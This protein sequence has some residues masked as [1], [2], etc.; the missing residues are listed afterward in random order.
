[1][2]QIKHSQLGRFRNGAIALVLASTAALAACGPTNEPV[3]EEPAVDPN[4]T[5]EE[6]V[7]E[8]P[9]EIAEEYNVA[10]GDLTGNVEDY[11]GQAV[12]VRGEAE[13][14]L[15]E[16]SFLLQDDQLF[17]GEEVV[18]FNATGTPFLLPTDDEPTEDVQV[19]GEV[20]QLV[21]ADFEREYGLDLD[22]QLYTEY[23]DRPALVAES[24]AFSP[25]PEEVTEQPEQYYGQT[26]AVSGEIGEQF[27]T[28]AFRLQEEGWFEG[29]EVLVIGA[30]VLPTVEE[31]EE[32]VVTG[33][34]RPYVA[35]EFERDYDL[36]WDLDLQEQIEAE[37]TDRPV[38]VADEVYPSAQ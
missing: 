6:P 19:T 24:I 14:A 16:S 4:V 15:G 36:T 35:A 17:G 38:L 21:V 10:L 33:T 8:E 5:T 31:G 18:V 7:A 30:S 23:E 27:S 12:S 32:V 37:Y 22:P 1:M 26:I 13:T 11:L 3:A 34:L 9:A 2:T 29:D 28:N 20:R 25:D